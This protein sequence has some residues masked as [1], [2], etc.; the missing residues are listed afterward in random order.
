[1]FVHSCRLWVVIV[2]LFARN[3]NQQICLMI[4]LQSNLLHFVLIVNGSGVIRESREG[5][6][7]SLDPLIKCIEFVKCQ[8]LLLNSFSCE[9]YEVLILLTFLWSAIKSL[10]FTFLYPLR[11]FIGFAA[12][13]I[14]ST[15]SR[16]CREGESDDHEP[17]NLSQH[18]PDSIMHPQ[19]PQQ[20]IE[21][22][23]PK[24]RREILRL[25]FVRH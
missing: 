24:L 18:Q 7:S 3:P 20:F 10:N 25:F 1:M 4:C 12:V 5:W 14:A 11:H 13:K 21:S 8:K 15:L 9:F 6:K 23:R 2:N 22:N 16:K 17:C 19:I